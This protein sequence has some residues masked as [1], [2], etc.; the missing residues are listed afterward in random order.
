MTAEKQV[1]DRKM[2]FELFVD[3][4]NDSQME[5]I[6]KVTEDTVISEKFPGINDF[7]RG[8]I[9]L[10][11]ELSFGISISDEEVSNPEEDAPNHAYSF[12]FKTVKEWIDYIENKLKA[13]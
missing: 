6:D 5:N 1:M 11:T 10:E 8:E 12:K 2:I 7:D 4:L 3:I 13:L 9:V